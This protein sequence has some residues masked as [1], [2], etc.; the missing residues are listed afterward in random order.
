MS[1]VEGKNR[2]SFKSNNLIAVSKS[3]EKMLKENYNVP[4][5]KIVMMYNSINPL[6][7]AYGKNKEELRNKLGIPLMPKLFYL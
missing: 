4:V 3:V 5:N 6:D 7:I 2:L 1:L